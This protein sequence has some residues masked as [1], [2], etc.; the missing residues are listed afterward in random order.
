MALFTLN[1][2]KSMGIT[3]EMLQ[4][5][6]KELERAIIVSLRQGDVTT[7]YSSFQYVVLLMNTSEENGEKVVQR[8]L[9]TWDEMNEY[10]GIQLDYAIKQVEAKTK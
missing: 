3:H 6:M 1:Y 5:A 10:S 4:K 7:Q 8:I 2:I 9:D